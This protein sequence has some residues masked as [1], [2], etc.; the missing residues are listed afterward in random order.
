MKTTNSFK[1]L[2]MIVVVA[3]AIM[4]LTTDLNGQVLLGRYDIGETTPEVITDNPYNLSFSDLVVNGA[5]TFAYEGGLL[6]TTNWGTMGIT[7][8]NIYFTVQR[9]GN[10][11]FKVSYVK[12]YYN[13]GG[14]TNRNLRLAVND[15]NIQTRNPMGLGV[16]NRNV[17]EI[18]VSTTAPLITAHDVIIPHVENDDAQ[19]F[20]IGANNNAALDFDKIEIYGLINFKFFE[21]FNHQS[22]VTVA[23]TTGTTT[24]DFTTI[25]IDSLRYPGWT[26]STGNQY[27]FAVVNDRTSNLLLWGTASDSA[28]LKSPSIDLSSPYEI[29]FE[30]RSRIGAANTGIL[31][32]YDNSGLLW[33]GL[34]TA[35]SFTAISTEGFVGSAT[36]NITFSVPQTD[37]SE[38][39]VD[40][41]VIYPTTKPALNFALQ[42]T[43]ALGTATNSTSQVFTIPLQAANL[44]GDVTLSLQS[45]TEF[46]LSGGTTVTQAIAETGTDIEITFNAP[47]SVGTYTDVLTISAAGTADRVVTLSAISDLGT[48]TI[49]LNDG[50]VVINGNQLI[51]NGHADKKATIY[52]LSGAT[53]FVQDR[54]SDN[55]VY[56]LPSKGVYLLKMEGDNMMPVTTKVMIR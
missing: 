25:D 6:K 13:N 33:N 26:G 47:E 9:N 38:Q 39:V 20:K 46:T 41:I 1:K 31:N 37:N 19:T 14:V 42:T 56:T 35:T 27:A 18:Y 21:D 30:Y 11:N 43:K 2:L 3:W 8:K 54:I 51:I 15:I 22:I 40:N 12:I 32:V 10:Q 55:Q 49:N 23:K 36:E 7:N 52:N 24:A 4:G 28:Y 53:L 29:Q 34:S 16:Q 17:G 5:I 48:S 45:G 50:S 44:T